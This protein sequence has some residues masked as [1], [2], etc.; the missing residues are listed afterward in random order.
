MNRAPFLLVVFTL[1]LAHFGYAV[2]QEFLKAYGPKFGARFP[3][4]RSAPPLAGLD[5]VHRWNVIA[6]NATGLDHTPVAPG[7]TRTFGEQLGPGRSSRA[8]AIIHMAIFDALNAVVGDRHGFSGEQRPRRPISADAAIAQG[9]HDTLVALYPSQRP[10]FD[11]RLAEDLAIVRT[12]DTREN[13]VNLGKRIA[14]TILASRANDG[15]ETPEPQ[16]NSEWPTSSLPGHWR[17]D[18]ISLI[19][20]ALGA[21]WGSCRPFVLL[22]TTQFRCPAPPDL[23]SAQYTAA[24]NDAKRLGGDGMHTPTERTAEQTFIGTFWAY[25]GTPSLCAPPRLYN[26]LIVTIA[27]QTHLNGLQLAR[28]LA[29][30][31]VAMSDEAFTCWESKYHWDFWR[32]VGGI[33]ESD[34]GPGGPGDGNPDTIADPTFMP[35]GAPASNL[36]GPN[37]TPPFPTYPSGHASFGGALFQIL[38]RFFGTDNVEFTFISDEYNGTTHANDGTIRP[39]I[40]RTFNTFSQAEEEN[41]QSRIYL[42]IHW[43]FDKTEGI[44]QGRLVGD[45]VYDHILTAARPEP[46]NKISN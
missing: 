1:C 8:M 31:N 15:S 40:P 44:N 24:Y 43:E 6:I 2:D 46:Q 25:D 33:R 9:A 18:P 13:S 23:T 3:I 14:A 35:L 32:P 12:F 16:V 22:S 45:Y 21:H 20:L 26:Q 30:A 4:D 5:A 17:Q 7:E 41:G 19:P 28:L 38:R 42:G 27:D 39:Y 37:F 36:V 10:G 11:A 34:A 29:V